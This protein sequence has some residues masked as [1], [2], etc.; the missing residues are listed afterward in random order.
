MLI[1][2]TNGLQYPYGEIPRADTAIDRCWGNEGEACETGDIRMTN[3]SCA[4]NTGSYISDIIMWIY[5]HLHV[6][7]MATQY[8]TEGAIT[9]PS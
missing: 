1:P 3:A 7:Y 8:C 2:S 9:K 4:D 5:S 6:K